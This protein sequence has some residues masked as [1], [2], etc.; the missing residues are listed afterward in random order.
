MSKDGIQAF[1]D[2]VTLIRHEI[3]KLQRTS[4]NK[5]EAKALHKIVANGVK[6]MNESGANVQDAIDRRL[7]AV[8][9]VVRDSASEAAEIAVR[10]L[11]D[12]NHAET[13]KA[14][15]SLSV[16]AGA[17]RREA[18][19]HF[20][21]FWVWIAAMLAT[22]IIL[23]LLLAYGTETAKSFFSVE[24]TIRY[25]CGK[26]WGSGQVI[27]RDDGASYCAHWIVTPSQAAARQ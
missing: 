17:A 18:W 11:L 21:G 25:S 3:D 1:A 13:L 4:L 26:S 7:L 24:Q 6:Q 2:E 16:A 14:A 10:D 8:A 23:G 19:R 27:N 15:K 5:D 20:G 9:A 12:K 22:G